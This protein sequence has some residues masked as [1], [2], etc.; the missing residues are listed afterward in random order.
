MAVKTL[1]EKS[2]KFLDNFS[3]FAI[4]REFRKFQTSL[5][6]ISEIQKSARQVSDVLDFS[7]ILLIFYA[8]VAHKSSTM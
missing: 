2:V 5:V 6:M 4:L 1:T 3:Y 8:D 7:F